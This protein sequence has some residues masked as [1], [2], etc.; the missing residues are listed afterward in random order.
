MLRTLALASLVLA[1][2]CKKSS[3]LVVGVITNLKVK[4]ELSNV[5]MTVA[6]EGVVFQN[7]SWDISDQA[8]LNFVLPGSINLFSED[9][10]SPRTE[11]EIKGYRGPTGALQERVTRR[12]VIQ[13]QPEQDLFYRMSLV[14]SCTVGSP[15]ATESCPVGFACVEGYCKEETVDAA[16]LTAFSTGRDKVVEC[17][18]GSAFIDSATCS[19]G[20]CAELPIMG[21]CAPD[22][23]CTEGAC[24][25]KN[26]L[27]PRK[28]DFGQACDL[29]SGETCRDPSRF[30]CGSTPGT[31]GTGAE[32]CRVSCNV[33]GDCQTATNLLPEAKAAMLSPTVARCT[34]ANMGP[35]VCTYTCDPFK[36]PSGCPSGSSC[37]IIGDNMT[38]LAPDCVALPTGTTTPGGACTPGIQNKIDCAVGAACVPA[39]SGAK[40]RTLCR[41]DGTVPCTSGGCR[42]LNVNMSTPSTEYGVCCSDAGCQL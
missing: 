26:P 20:T 42:P 41:L 24:Y 31:F 35:S 4:G 27:A 17:N 11:I 16:T 22:E 9:G 28:L 8:A 34:R 30:A 2:G 10:G 14:L 37:Q 25:K 32:R 12:A 18:S 7:Y 23:F 19:T 21:S 29:A 38:L 3:Q 40:C 15:S 5:Q 36:L 13:L 1:C 6:R 33:D 39:A